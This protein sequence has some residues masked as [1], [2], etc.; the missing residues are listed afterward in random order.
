MHFDCF[1]SEFENFAILRPEGQVSLS[2]SEIFEF[3][4][5]FEQHLRRKPEA[6]E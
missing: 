5:K 6:A 1:R 3:I 4:E 2:E